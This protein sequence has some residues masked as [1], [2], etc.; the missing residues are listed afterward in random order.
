MPL[1]A[2]VALTVLLCLAGLTP[3]GAQAASSDSLPREL[4][5]ALFGSL[6]GSRAS[7]RI[8][9]SVIDSAIPRSVVRGATPLGMAAFGASAISVARFPFSGEATLDS[10]RA[11]LV[12]EG[13][14]D[15]PSEMGPRPRGLGS[16]MSTVSIGPAG[17]GG[18][19][20]CGARELLRANVSRE[21]PSGATVVFAAQA[22]ARSHAMLCTA[23]GQREFAR[24]DLLRNSPVPELPPPR[25]MFSAGAGGGGAPEDGGYQLARLEGPLAVPRIQSHYDS[26][27]TAAGWSIVE[28]GVGTGFATTIF[29][30]RTPERELW[31]AVI[32]TVA[33]PGSGLADVSLLTRVV[34]N[35]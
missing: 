28:R 18:L 21:D 4:V 20:L 35:R 29:E 30:L 32:A 33:S 10:I 22:D 9:V 6:G 3:A 13:Y 16:G 27:F 15:P 34:R 23:D 26:L 14:T 5:E 2:S 24:F 25:G 7:T 11:R 1:R 31:R 12:R 17:R 19:A 8:T